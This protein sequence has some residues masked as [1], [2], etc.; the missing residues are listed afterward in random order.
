[1]RRSGAVCPGLLRP[2]LRSEVLHPGLLRGHLL[3]E[4][5]LPAVPSQ[6]LLR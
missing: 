1:V 2:G 3:P 6:E 4:A 5:P